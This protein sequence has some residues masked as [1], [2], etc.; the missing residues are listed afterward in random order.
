VK[1]NLFF[2]KKKNSAEVA[3]NF[4]QQNQLQTKSSVAKIFG[5]DPNYFRAF[6]SRKKARAAANFVDRRRLRKKLLP[7]HLVY[8]FQL[9][10]QNPFHKIQWYQRKMQEHLC[11]SISCS[12]IWQGLRELGLSRVKVQRYARLK[13]TPRNIER[14]HQY[15]NLMENA[16]HRNLVFLD[17]FGVNKK[18][19]DSKYGWTV[20]GFRLLAPGHYSRS[21]NL[22][23]LLLISAFGVLG[24]VVSPKPFKS[25]SF[26][27]IVES[28]ILPAFQQLHQQY[29]ISPV[30]IM[31]NCPFHKTQDVKVKE[32]II[33]KKKKKKFKKKE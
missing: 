28:F 18:N 6:C 2:L 14:I 13:S 12:S 22:S 3:L 17:E 27:A 24:Q 25:D 4:H 26:V 31:D 29:N 11:Q 5:L 30:L 7:H 23:I 9:V 8:L 32:E 20:R 16:D 15:L 21:S 33:K 10:H 1:I 19:L